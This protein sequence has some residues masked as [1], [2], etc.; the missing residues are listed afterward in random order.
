MESV[1][2]PV[3]NVGMASSVAS[4]ATKVGVIDNG[5]ITG[6]FMMVVKFNSSDLFR[7]K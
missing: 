1:G 2:S 5:Y 3:D 7:Y 6:M 4:R